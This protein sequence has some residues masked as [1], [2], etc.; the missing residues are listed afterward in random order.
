MT[1]SEKAMYLN[2]EAAACETPYLVLGLVL[3]AVAVLFY[4]FRFPEVKDQ[5]TTIKARQFFAGFKY[6]H[7]KWAVSSA[8]LLCRRAGLRNQLFY[9]DGKTG[10]RHR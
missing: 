3:V 1:V 6:S 2:T 8:V 9:Q 7:L 4:F 5:T 10:C